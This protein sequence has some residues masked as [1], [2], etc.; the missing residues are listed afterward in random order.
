M[1][2]QKW[3]KIGDVVGA[4]E[5][6]S[7]KKLYNGREYDYVFDIEI[8]DTKSKLKLPY[9]KTDSPYMAAQTFIHQHELSQFYL[10]EIANH[11]IKN[12]GGQTIATDTG[13]NADPLTGDDQLT[14][15]A[16][17]R[18]KWLHAFR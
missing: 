7:G 17:S 2:E 18:F 6:N 11:I 12:T 3:N 1:A 15:K 10:D 9:N 14:S 5:E 16:I 4:A 13:G 8:D